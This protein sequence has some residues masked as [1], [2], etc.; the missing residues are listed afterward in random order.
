M[1]GTEKEEVERVPRLETGRKV[2]ST[3]RILIGERREQRAKS[4]QNRGIRGHM[5]GSSRIQI[6]R[7]H[8]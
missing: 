5:E 2:P 7:G 8:T 3:V 1:S 6:P 4:G